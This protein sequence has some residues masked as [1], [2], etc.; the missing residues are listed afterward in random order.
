MKDAQ[1]LLQA[2]GIPSV[3]ESLCGGIR[4]DQVLGDGVDEIGGYHQGDFSEDLQGD[5]TSPWYTR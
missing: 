4:V 2:H 5:S 1:V 3:P